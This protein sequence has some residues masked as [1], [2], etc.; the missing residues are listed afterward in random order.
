MMVAHLMSRLINASDLETPVTQASG[1]LLREPREQ[2]R[3]EDEKKMVK[4]KKDVGPVLPLAHKQEAATAP[5]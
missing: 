5:Q 4:V 2:T 3:V 1:A